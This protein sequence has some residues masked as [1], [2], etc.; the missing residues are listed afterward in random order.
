[1]GDGGNQINILLKFGAKMRKHIFL[2]FYVAHEADAQ[3]T[4]NG[5]KDIVKI[6]F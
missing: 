5:N 4:R 3:N 1:M 6:T 2:F